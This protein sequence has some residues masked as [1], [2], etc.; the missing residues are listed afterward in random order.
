MTIARTQTPTEAGLDATRALALDALRLA[1][2]LP[3]SSRWPARW[4]Q[5]AFGRDV[6]RV[7]R[8]LARIRSQRTLAAAYRREVFERLRPGSDRAEESAIRVAYALRWLEMEDGVT[9][10][11]WPAMTG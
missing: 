2:L 6:E 4:R 5:P 8:R 7:R 9:G 3:D 10:P 1:R 11:S